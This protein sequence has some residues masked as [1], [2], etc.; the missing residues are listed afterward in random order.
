VYVSGVPY[1]DALGALAQ[2]DCD[3]L[4]SRMF[5]TRRRIYARCDA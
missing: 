5:D 3:G 2:F 4:R 1:V